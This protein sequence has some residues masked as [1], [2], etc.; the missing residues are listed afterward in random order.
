VTSWHAVRSY[1]RNDCHLFHSH[2]SQ[3]FSCEQCCHFW[4][5]FSDTGEF[6]MSSTVKAVWKREVSP[7]DATVPGLHQLRFKTNIAYYLRGT[8]HFGCFSIIKAWSLC[9]FSKYFLLKSLIISTGCK[10][11]K[12]NKYKRPNIVAEYSWGTRFESRT[13]TDYADWS[14]QSLEPQA[15]VA[16]G[17]NS[18][19]R[20]QL[21]QFIS[22]RSTRWLFH[23][24]EHSLIQVLS[25]VWIAPAAG[26]EYVRKLQYHNWN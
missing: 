1:K 15:C 12:L 13:H 14:L 16:S 5:F 11:Y 3:H 6:L 21:I 10:M 22:N 7:R 24:F 19:Y 4:G 17:S 2:G 18:L 20:S 9:W 23:D 8:W 25:W 26:S